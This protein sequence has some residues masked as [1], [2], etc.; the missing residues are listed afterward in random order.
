MR[1]LVFNILSAAKINI[2]RATRRLTTKAAFRVYRESTAS[3]RNT[4]SRL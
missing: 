1:N 2:R 3:I 4:N